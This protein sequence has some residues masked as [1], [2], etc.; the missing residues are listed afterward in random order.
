MSVFN[1]SSFSTPSGGTTSF[2]VDSFDTPLAPTAGAPYEVPPF[3]LS[4]ITT[5][6]GSTTT[7]N[8]SLSATPGTLSTTGGAALNTVAA[9]PTVYSTGSAPTVSSLSSLTSSIAQWGFSLAGALGSSAQPTTRVVEVGS[10]TSSGNNNMILFGL[11]VL[12]VVAVII[13]VEE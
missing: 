10:T 7:P 5:P 2:M 8:P 4:S 3:D 1:A 9:N 11:L 12:A 6:G 13:I